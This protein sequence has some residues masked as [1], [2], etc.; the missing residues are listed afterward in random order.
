VRAS[1]TRTVDEYSRSLAATCIAAVVAVVFSTA[2]SPAP[3]GNPKVP[4]GA[5][6]SGGKHAVIET[7]KGPIEIE[8]FEK[9]QPRAV[10]NFRLLAEHG[11]Y[12]G[13][14]FHRVVKGFMVQGGDPNGNGTGGESAWGPPFADDIDPNSPLYRGGYRR[15]IVAMANSGP[16]TN[17]SQFFIMHDDYPLPPNYV[18][19][20][21]VTSGLSVVDALAT[22]PTTMGDDGAM[23]RPVTP[24][25]ITKVT[26]RP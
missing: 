9:E 11:Y 3:P 19:V 20:A 26:V 12:D 16:N 1:K 23:S 18:I 5:K 24:L 2:C 25:K 7:D 21:R 13:L 8:F 6:S 17:G 22:V 15:G 14:T 4:A 10:E